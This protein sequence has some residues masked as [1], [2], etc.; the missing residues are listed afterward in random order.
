MKSLYPLFELR[1]RGIEL[2]H[3]ELPFYNAQLLSRER[4]GNGFADSIADEILKIR[5]PPPIIRQ[6]SRIGSA[7]KAIDYIT[8]R[9]AWNSVVT[10]LL[11]AMFE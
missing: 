7:G 10:W 9:Y 2:T 4:N 5:R 8:S 11:G 6:M 3:V 1:K